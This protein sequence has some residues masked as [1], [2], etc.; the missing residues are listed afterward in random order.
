[1]KKMKLVGVA[2]VL[3]LS[4]STQLNVSAQGQLPNNDLVEIDSGF[5]EKLYTDERSL[6]ETYD[7]IISIQDVDIPDSTSNYVI[8]TETDEDGDFF[9]ELDCD[10]TLKRIEVNASDSVL[11]STNAESS[12]ANLYVLTAETKTSDGN[13]TEDEV[14]LRGTICWI[15]HV[16]LSNELKYVSGA[17]F[18]NFKDNGNYFYGGKGTSYGNGQFLYTFYDDAGSGSRNEWF[19]LNLNTDSTITGKHLTLIIYTSIL[20]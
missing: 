8:A 6:M 19:F 9:N 2:M 7:N 17:I 4:T 5:I 20:D 18:G 3:I 1:M 14:T 16:G 10:V 13:K 11:L 12:I 15:D